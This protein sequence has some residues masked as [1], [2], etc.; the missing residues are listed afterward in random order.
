MVYF[1]VGIFVFFQF[2]LLIIEKK[3]FLVFFFQLF[4]TSN[5]FLFSNKNTN[6]EQLYISFLQKYNK[7]PSDNNYPK[8]FAFFSNSQIDETKF[9]TFKQ[10]LDFIE[11]QNKHLLSNQNTFQLGT[12]ELFDEIPYSQVSSNVMKQ[13]FIPQNF[14]FSQKYSKFLHN[15]FQFLNKIM[16]IN[17]E[18]SWNN[19]NFLSNVKNQGRCG[20]CW[21]F[22]ATSS[23]E[24]FMRSK[25]Y[26]VTR[27]SEQELVDCSSQNYGCNGGFMHYAFDYVIHQNG[28][29]EEYDYPYN[30]KDNNCTISC[31]NYSS[32]SFFLNKTFG[33]Q[34]SKY[35]FTIPNSIVDRIISLQTSPICIALDASSIF[36]QYYKSGIIDIQLN[37]SNLNHAVLLIGYGFDD[38]GM[39]WIIQNSWGTSW[40]E[41]GYCKIRVQKGD[42]ILLTN[43]YGV[44]PTQLN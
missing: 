8:P 4:V 34:L 22:S 15:P 40:G 3:M 30:A 5:S 6:Y 27:L 38:A 37:N 18:F 24:T 35:E 29:T 21:A 16:N 2:T 10:N 36:F 43:V 7:L 44:Y 42:G 41:N 23:L 26:N 25:G 20:S 13:P 1:L 32:S 28:L 14:T 31:S 19:T 9:N 11:T 12:N 39:Y 33:S 17:N